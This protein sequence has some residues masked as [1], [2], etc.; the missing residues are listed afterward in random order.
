MIGY[1]NDAQDTA[2]TQQLF[3]EIGHDQ[4]ACLVKAA[5]STQV[6]GFEVFELERGSG[7]W[8]DIFYEVKAAS[9][10]L[11]RQYRETHCYYN[12][13]EAL[14]I[15][16]QQFSATAAEDYLSLVYGESK[17]H[18]VRYEI[19]SPETKTVNAYRLRRSIHEL[20]GR[21]FVLYQPHH[22]YSA[23]LN[24]LYANAHAGD[25]LVRMQFYHRHVIVA[26]VKQN[27]LQLIQSF[28]YGSPDD[29]LYYVLSIIQQFGI[30]P[31]GSHLEISG[32]FE[33]NTTLHQQL[34]KLFGQVSF[35][36]I[37]ADA[38]FTAAIAQYPAHYFT[39]FYKLAV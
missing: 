3:L 6:E 34:N 36:A 27:K 25:Q 7:D 20:V 18:E 15:S 16:E 39:P 24:A 8:S 17:A 28:A 37:V 11:N 2:A 10:I 21:H 29:V 26:L 30:T 4:L 23:I 19:L 9:E 14:I 31:I 32:M 33:L 1:Y 38:S 13:E 22:T 35:D 5:G 12:F